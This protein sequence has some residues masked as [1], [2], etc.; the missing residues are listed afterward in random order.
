[1]PLPGGAAEKCGNRY[2]GCWTVACMLDVMDEKVDSIRLEPPD[3]E[4]QGFEFRTT[5]Q[6][7]QEYHQVKRQR[8]IGHWTLN[9]L[10]K[11]GVL[12]NFLAKLHTDPT[13]HCVFVSAISAGQFAELSDR[14][15]RSADWEEFNT[16]FIDSDQ[17]RTNFDLVRNSHSGLQKQ[18]TYELLKR[19]HIRTLDESTLRTM[20]E[21]RASMLVDE[22]AATVVDV[23]AGLALDR[24]HHKLTALDIR[25]HLESKGLRRRHWDNDP[26]VL[27]AVEAATNR[28]LNPLRD[29]AINRTI[30]PRQEVQTVR[31][32][33][34]K[35][36]EKA[37][38]LVTGEAGIGK[39]GVMLQVVE[40]L[41]DS[42]IPVV[43]LRADQ[44]EFTLLPDDV[45]KQIGLPGSPANVLA[46]VAQRRH[47]V[48]AIDQLDALSLASGRN[49][50]LFDCI[51][52]IVLQAQAHPKMRI[53]LACR[54]FDLDNDH[55][56]RQLTDA[57]GVAEAMTVERMTHE[58]V[59][60]VVAD[61]GLDA[62]SLN[63][64]QLDLL[65][66]PLHLKL[67]SEL[68]EDEEIRALNFEKA[69]DLYDRF[70]QFKQQ[71]IRNRRGRPLQWT[72]VVYA[73]CDY[74]HQRQL[75]SAPEVIVEDWNDDA[76]AMASEHVLVY[77]P[78][79]RRFSFFHEGFFDYAYARRFA[80]DPQSLLDLLV[81]GEQHLFRRA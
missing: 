66:V 2:E 39:S 33:L 32:H 44:L 70:W 17:M 38:V 26:H 6:D 34:E 7:I 3:L 43:A 79:K 54:K 76:E 8:S 22:D 55:R 18:E 10:K 19:V 24:I 30:L 28:Y 81:S 12:T 35:S 71:L 49:T 50:N 72:K 23:L 48:L 20:I 45:G 78:D 80:R 62:N 64:K 37:G 61:L 27:K 5:K 31:E 69:Q 68:E 51:Y 74:M 60:E 14:A 9:A 21:S 73:L 46:T 56:L 57:D 52:E 67:L 42:G 75:L 15:R 47:C 53:L 4:G 36:S 11:E 59:R 41:L 65:S 29:Q 40:E 1:M 16:E 25:S 63:S 58:T 77:V 13:V